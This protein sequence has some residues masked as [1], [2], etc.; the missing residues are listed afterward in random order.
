MGAK[1]TRVHSKIIHEAHV[2]SENIQRSE[3]GSRGC[4]LCAGRGT[5]PEHPAAAKGTRPLPPKSTTPG[6]RVND[7]CNRHGK[8]GATVYKEVGGHRRTHT[9]TSDQGWSTHDEHA[10][11]RINTGNLIRMPPKKNE[12]GLGPGRRDHYYNTRRVAEE[13]MM[14]LW[15]LLIRKCLVRTVP[16]L[17]MTRYA[18]ILRFTPSSCGGRASETSFDISVAF[19][20][21][22]DDMLLKTCVLTMLCAWSPTTT[23][24][25]QSQSARRAPASSASSWTE[26]DAGHARRHGGVVPG[27]RYQV[28]VRITTRATVGRS[29]APLRGRRL[30]APSWT[31][32]SSR[33]ARDGGR[34]RSV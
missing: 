17:D 19:Q 22:T 30:R 2:L 18:R 20:P 28:V 23:V 21:H 10:R 13:D 33:N 32:G 31:G 6:F 27:S 34:P 5:D 16:P 15:T 3:P 25:P 26:R 24:G 4:L 14:Y 12:R 11:W 7:K 29:S 9:T 1:R 8:E